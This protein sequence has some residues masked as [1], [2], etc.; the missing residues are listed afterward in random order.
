[1][2]AM[3]TTHTPQEGLD[4]QKPAPALDEAVRAVEEAD[5]AAAPDLADELARRLTELLEGGASREQS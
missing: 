5:A 4:G 2:A 1:M 3:D